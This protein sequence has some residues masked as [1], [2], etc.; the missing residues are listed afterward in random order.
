LPDSTILVPLAISLLMAI[1]VVWLAWRVVLAGGRLRMEKASAGE[2]ATLA[3]QVDKVL[4]EVLAH[5]DEMRRRK[6]AP[7]D[8]MPALQ[9]ATDAL[10]RY[11]D[12]AVTFGRNP[13]WT[14]MSDAL[15]AD[16]E[17]A[18]RAIDL[19]VHGGNLMADVPAPDA[20]EG[21]TAVKRGYVNLVHARE[22]IRERREA[23]VAASSSSSPSGAGQG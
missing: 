21:E 6:V 10:S 11:I 23:I 2:V 9:A 15:V 16:I 8:V 14:A 19:I 7:A 3:G 4:E 5:V 1:P 12:E 20:T 18:Q 17:R 22:T 13:A